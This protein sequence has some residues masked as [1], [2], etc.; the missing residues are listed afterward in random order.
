MEKPVFTVGERTDR[1][2]A[3]CGEERGHIVRS[4]TKRGQIS[5]VS[6]S[7][8]GTVSVFKPICEPPLVRGAKRLHP[9]TGH[10]HTGQGSL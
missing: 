7:K 10:T 1:L 9:T 2:C 8:C 3:M 6:C 5:R 4:V